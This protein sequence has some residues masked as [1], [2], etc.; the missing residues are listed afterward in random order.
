MWFKKAK[1]T[2]ITRIHVQ[3]IVNIIV[4]SLCYVQT[5]P[6]MCIKLENYDFDIVTA[7]MVMDL[8]SDTSITYFRSHACSSSVAIFIDK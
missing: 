7:E 6:Y 2:A 3:R 1:I 8:V 4:E 5:L